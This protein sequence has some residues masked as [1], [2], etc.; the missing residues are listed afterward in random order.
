MEISTAN[1]ASVTVI[2]AVVA[3]ADSE[4]LTVD[5]AFYARQR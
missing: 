5:N 3:H 1:D 2:D 4:L